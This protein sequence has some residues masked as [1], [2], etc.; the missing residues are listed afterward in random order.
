MKEMGYQP[1]SFAKALATNRSDTI[2]MVVSDLSGPF[3]G[4]MM[5]H[6][7]DETRKHG[8]HLIITSGHDTIESESDAIDFLMK[9]RVDALLLHVD[10]LTDED[11]IQLCDDNDIPIILINRLVPELESQCI[12][13][14][15]DMGGFLATQ[16]LIDLGH[17]DIACI[18]GP[19]FKADARARL[20]GYRRAIEMAGIDYDERLVIE[21]DYQEK[22]GNSSI[23]RLRRRGVKFTSVV[24]QNDHMAIGA[25]KALKAHGLKIPQDVSV[26][27]YDDMVMARYTEPALTTVSIPVAEFGQQAADMALAKLGDKTSGATKQFQPE[28]IV[29]ASTGKVNTI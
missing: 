13:L 4:D 22:G 25:M 15:N 10:A 21:S 14:D 5:R 11:I 9:R 8:K 3:F 26:V 16:H 24:A 29:R 28:L 19:L 12:S 20:A 7:E 6:A 27:G 18:T 2:G 1:N 23:E 17:R